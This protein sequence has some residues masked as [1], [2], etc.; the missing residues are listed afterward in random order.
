MGY[1]LPIR[2][3]RSE[4]YA[5]RMSMEPY[6][7]AYIG[8]VQPMKLKSGFLEEFEN[9]TNSWKEE[10]PMDKKFSASPAHNP[11]TGYVAPNPANL[12]PLIALTVGKGIKVN[13]YV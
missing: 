12:S 5:N 3:I 1:L 11:Y 7:F 8:S 4:Q 13:T 6:N 9:K 10:Q 2:S